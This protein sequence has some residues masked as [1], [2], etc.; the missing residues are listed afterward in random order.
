MST[1]RE[2]TAAKIHEIYM[3]E[4]RR[5]SD[6]RHKDAYED[7]PENIKEFD[8]VLADWHAQ[9]LKAAVEGVRLEKTYELLQLPSEW[10]D[11]LNDR[12]NHKIIYLSQQST[13]D[14]YNR[15]VSDLERAKAERLR[16]LG[17]V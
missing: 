2:R 15:A 13:S 5:H 16:E 17:I 3:K 4:A 14:G 1:W 7:L 10:N 9:E 6:V 11:A 12:D 8:R